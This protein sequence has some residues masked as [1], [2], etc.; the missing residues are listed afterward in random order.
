MIFSK[1]RLRKT[2]NKIVFHKEEVVPKVDDVSLVDEVLMVHLVEM[3]KRMVSRGGLI[4]VRYEGDED[5][6]NNGNVAGLEK[7]MVN[8]TENQ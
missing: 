4:E 5:D 3:K 7:R 1:F 2:L 8:C 6:K